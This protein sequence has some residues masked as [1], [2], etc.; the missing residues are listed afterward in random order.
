M[1][2]KV[3][4]VAM[5]CLLAVTITAP[6][7]ALAAPAAAA[8]GTNSTYAYAE[9]MMADWLAV[10]LRDAANKQGQVVGKSTWRW[11]DNPDNGGGLTT[12]TQ[13]ETDFWLSALIFDSVN[14]AYEATRDA[15]YISLMD[16]LYNGFMSG[17]HPTW[18][19]NNWTANWYNDD[20][21]WWGQAFARSYTLTGDQ[22][23]LDIAKQMFDKLFLSWDESPAFGGAPYGGI[24]WRNDTPA[25]GNQK[26]VCTEAN[27]VIVAARLSKI[28]A[29]VSDT[30]DSAYYADKAKRIYDWAYAHLY[31]ANGYMIDGVNY[32]GTES[33]SQ[34]TYNYGLF[35]G[36][37]YEMNTLTGDPSYAA[38]AAQVL[39]YGWNTMTLTDGLTIKDEGQGDSAGFKLEFIRETGLMVKAGYAQF[40]KYL[41]AN[42]YQ[43]WNHRRPT[44]GLC[45]SNLSMAPK[46]DTEIAGPCS[47]VGPV[48]LY[49]SGIDPTAPAPYTLVSQADGVNGVYQTE[50]ATSY[51]I[52]MDSS[53]AG[54]TGSGYSQYWDNDNPNHLLDGWVRYDITVPVS[55]VY[56]LDFRWF[57]RGD[58]TRRISINGGQDVLLN[59]TRADSNVWEDLNYYAYLNAGMN[60]VKL[61][62]YN[63]NNKTDHAA[64]ADMD[65][66]LFIDCLTVSDKTPYIIPEQ[67][68]T[69]NNVNF[70]VNYTDGWNGGNDGQSVDYTVNVDKAGKYALTFFYSNNSNDAGRVLIVNGTPGASL[71][72]FPKIGPG[73]SQCRTVTVYDANL[74]AGTN[75]ISVANDTARG[76]SNYINLLKYVSVLPA[77][78]SVDYANATLING[79]FDANF[80][81]TNNQTAA[82]TLTAIIA[83]YDGNGALAGLTPQVVTLAPGEVKPLTGSFTGLAPGVQYTAKVFVWDLTFMPLGN[84]AAVTIS[85]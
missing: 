49:Y 77:A 81:L 6:A 27:A 80:A 30:A 29:S 9:K 38:T 18:D 3:L 21:C 23:Y 41:D 2:K 28:Y 57:T 25:S 46:F 84:A 17:N 32:A 15:K 4:G 58:N 59:F 45:G 61:T 83:V 73:W 62:Y 22:K 37:S 71:L 1:F 43:A 33:S 70:L 85:G 56:K 42:A 31:K 48:A 78:V 44:D 66:W 5:A 14:D 19:V 20:L 65:S 52:Q 7:T 50:F 39:Q 10:Y 8:G 67:T 51:D 55:G 47:V 75:T 40:Q 74:A 54:Y 82:Q 26:N 11:S 69:P 64:N 72:V 79:K 36:A 12:E 35:A 53:Q 68:M 16:Q 76:T 63:K 13:R 24:L 34:F 60:T